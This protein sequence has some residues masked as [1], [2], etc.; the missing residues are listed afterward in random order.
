MS[1]GG[2]RTTHTFAPTTPKKASGNAKAGPDEPARTPR[3][4]GLKQH[5]RAYNP[6][7]RA[8]EVVL[9]GHRTLSG[10]RGCPRVGVGVS[11]SCVWV[12]V[13]QVA[14]TTRHFRRRASAP[15][16]V[17]RGGEPSTAARGAPLG[18]A[19]TTTTWSAAA[20]GPPRLRARGACMPDGEP[21][22]RRGCGGWWCEH[23]GWGG[24]AGVE[25]VES[26]PGPDHWVRPF[27]LCCAF[28]ASATPVRPPLKGPEPFSRHL[29][30]VVNP[31][32]A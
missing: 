18:R 21:L 31:E 20:P 28:S 15:R 19:S 8:G 3:H 29:T 17:A 13:R 25:P 12:G 5:V 4:A 27:G 16:T 23:P 10:W 11:G 9:A 32:P 22:L 14:P 26:R 24:V 1:P 6:H 7:F 30:G 2:A